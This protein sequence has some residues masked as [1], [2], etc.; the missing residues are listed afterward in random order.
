MSCREAGTIVCESLS[1]LGVSCVFGLPGSQN[2][3]LF[4][5]LRRSSLR[6]VPATHELAA[7]F[8]ANG[9]ARASGRPGVLVTGPGPGFAWTLPGLTEAFL[10]SVPLLYIV[11]ESVSPRGR[12]FGLQQIDQNALARP[13]V[14]SVRNVTQVSAVGEAVACAHEECQSG[15]PGPVLV[16][17]AGRL[18]NGQ[19]PEVQ[20]PPK[21][22]TSADP[23]ADSTPAA[24]SVQHA[25]DAIAASNR[26]LLY[27]G[28]GANSAA[29]AVRELAEV[30][31]APVITTRS[32][33]G[34]LPENHPL[35]IVFNPDGDSAASLNRLID[36]SDLVLALG[37][38]FSHNGAA[39]FRLRIPREKLIHVDASREV[40]EANYPARIA[41]ESKVAVFLAEVLKDRKSLQR[42]PIGWEV[43]E[44]A[45]WRRL[46]PAEAAKAMVEPKFQG[47][48]P[49]T[50]AAFFAALREA[51]PAKGC[52][53]TDSGLHQ[54]MARV[55]FRVFSACGFIAPSDFQ[56]MGFGLPAA[57]GAKLA[58]PDRPVVAI[59]GD[60]GFA[61]SGME[62]LTAVRERTPLTVIV[63]NDCA[64]GQIRLHQISAFGVGHATSLVNPDFGLFAAAAG[65]RYSL[66][67]DDPTEILKRAI[68]GNEVQLVEV[69]LH[70][71]PAYRRRRATA[72]ARQ[73]GQRIL[74]PGLADAIRRRL[75]ARRSPGDD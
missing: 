25:L 14:K 24:E 52:L 61:M 46:L 21:T 71:S 39:G 33:R 65:I 56:S 45:R 31:H 54:E 20:G 18:L 72:L 13:V 5:A 49:P 73:A 12:K 41:I 17:I 51:M 8:M 66:L 3:R 1:R 50:A 59:V 68:R 42:R 16:Q 47:I 57:I 34:L 22:G 62:L 74:G 19:Q 15:E 53:V 32:A 23:E 40:L 7:A 37:C 11:Q 9:Y 27:C 44:I 26:A 67:A 10:D 38:K 43:D 2:I 64:L 60:G 4:E 55:H 63:F 70:D 29:E 35:S 28:Q 30:L 6:T 75:R 48:A 69:R 36:R 58:N